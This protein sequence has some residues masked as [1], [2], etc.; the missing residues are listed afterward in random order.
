MGTNAL[1]ENTRLLARL[2]LRDHKGAARSLRERTTPLSALFEFSATHG[3][4]VVLLDAIR[5]LSLGDAFPAQSVA[6]LQ[7]RCEERQRRTQHLL[8]ELERVADGFT[9]AG[10]PMLLL[11]GPYLAARFYGSALGREFV[12]LDLLVPRTD[13][14][15]AFRL[16]GDLGYIA[17]SR[18]V[19]GRDLTCY[20]V[21]GF[22]FSSGTSHL[23][24][25]WCLSRHPSLRIDERAI[26]SRRRSYTIG[27][28]A[29]DVL[30]DDYEIV[31]AALSLLRDVERG[32]PKVKNMIDLLR[33]LAH[34]DRRLDWSA[35]FDVRRGE[36]TLSPAVNVL[37]LCLDITDAYDLVPNLTAALARYTELRVAGLR[38]E[39]SSLFTPA[40]LGIGNKLWCARVYDTSMAAWLLW[41]T[42]S[43]PFRV[44]VHRR[45]ALAP[46]SPSNV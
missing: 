38:A 39:S 45:A 34:L 7:R 9:A 4:S 41:W 15:R 21:H 20:F 28:H 18:T 26:W 42:V 44:A 40:A 13:R 5:E 12:D 36:G 11:K 10:Q 3:L 23:D 46:R 33:I 29:Y 2:A 14:A 1:L 37:A 17:R 6:A 16:L 43:L 32:R 8:V 30:P 24:L 27:S 35:F 19:C 31:F 25:H 22:D